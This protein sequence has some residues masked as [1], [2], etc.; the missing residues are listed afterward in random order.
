MTEASRLGDCSGG[1]A[2]RRT[3]GLV[4]AH[5]LPRQHQRH[6]RRRA[7]VCEDEGEGEGEARPGEAGPWSL[8]MTLPAARYV[9]PAT[10][11]CCTMCGRAAA[12]WRAATRAADPAS[13]VTE[14]LMRRLLA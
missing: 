11:S 12:Y 14:L 9:A 2:R 7:V 6:D 13:S 8:E 5:T 4:G 1:G 3:G 10:C